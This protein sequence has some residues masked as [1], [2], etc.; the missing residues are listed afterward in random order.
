M[1]DQSANQE[2]CFNALCPWLIGEK[3]FAI[4]PY[5]NKIKDWQNII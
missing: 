4:S 5:E 2:G 1:E 3:G